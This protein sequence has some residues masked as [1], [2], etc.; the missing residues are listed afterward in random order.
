MHWPTAWR[1]C[2]SIDAICAE[3]N[4][5]GP[6]RFTLKVTDATG[7][8]QLKG[9]TTS[10]GFGDWDTCQIATASPL[11]GPCGAT[12]AALRASVPK[13]PTDPT[14]V[15]HS[16]QTCIA[17]KACALR[18]NMDNCDWLKWVIPQFVGKYLNKVERWPE[19]IEK[20]RAP[21]ALLSPAGMDIA[22][23]NREA[24]YHITQDLVPALAQYG[25]GTDDDWAKVYGVIAS[26]TGE[27]LSGYFPGSGTIASKGT[28]AYRQ[29]ARFTCLA[30]RQLSGQPMMINAS[31][32]GQTCTP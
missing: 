4:L 16:T 24:F 21:N 15:F 26:C 1:C 23:A 27:N 3:T 28:Y 9:G 8:W 6:A 5:G 25:C 11:S 30:Q 22:C 10:G 14:R 13:D 17:D 31:I 19:V 2:A 29:G 7:Y 20:C 18:C 32:Q 12:V